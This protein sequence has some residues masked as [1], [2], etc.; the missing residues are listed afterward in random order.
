MTSITAALPSEDTSLWS[1]TSG[2]T[3]SSSGD[4]QGSLV[5]PVSQ[6]GFGPHAASKMTYKG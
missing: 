3:C 4:G 5:S 6:V 2:A 1:K